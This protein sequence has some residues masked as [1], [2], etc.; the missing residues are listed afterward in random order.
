MRSQLGQLLLMIACLVLVSVRAEANAGAPWSGGS[1]AGE[2][3]GIGVVRI[4]HEE[5]VIDLRPLVEPDGLVSVAATYHL[6]NPGGEQRLDLVFAAGSG[7]TD[8][9]VVLDGRSVPFTPTTAEALPES[10][11]APGTT[12]LFDGG[13]L[14]YHL[15]GEEESMSFQL[16]VPP[17]GHDLAI[18]YRADAASYRHGDPTV[19]RQ[20]AYVLSPARTWAGFGGLDVSVHL[21]AGWNAAVTPAM[22]RDG[23]TLRRVFEDVPADA[24]A[25]TV[26]APVGNYWLVA[27][28]A[29][30]CFGSS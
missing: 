17:G 20:F 26:Q 16:V 15:V 18:S 4:A 3:G 29:G 6:E 25:L 19:L 7:T 10:W 28:A 12:P 9:Q 8:F 27:S 14:Q 5:L 21:P 1:R 22:D 13:E 2:P 11:R 30:W 24:I 23:D